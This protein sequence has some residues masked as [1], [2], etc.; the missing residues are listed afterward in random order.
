MR[1][2]VWSFG[3]FGCALFLGCAVSVTVFWSAVHVR[4]IG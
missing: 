4:V 3:N 2:L 1:C